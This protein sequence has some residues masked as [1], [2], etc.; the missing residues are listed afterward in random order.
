MRTFESLK[1]ELGI[2]CSRASSSARLRKNLAELRHP[3]AEN[4]VAALQL[5]NALPSSLALSVN[6]IVEA[7]H[8]PRRYLFSR[9]RSK[10]RR[11]SSRSS[12]S[13]PAMRA[14]WCERSASSSASLQGRLRSMLQEQPQGRE[15]PRPPT[16]RAF[17]EAMP[18]RTG[19]PLRSHRSC[20][21]R[22]SIVEK[23]RRRENKSLES[24]FRFRQSSPSSGSA[25]AA[26]L[27][28]P[29]K[30]GPTRNSITRSKGAEPGG[31]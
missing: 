12:S 28:R 17:P 22:I 15:R 18:A 20:G 13:R 27:E 2:F 26:V 16:R 9:S 23:A 5:F 6:E 1:T 19:R 30:R 31:A 3:Q 29:Q 24:F 10:P 11:V 7:V 8:P 4:S 25:A 14:R 21:N